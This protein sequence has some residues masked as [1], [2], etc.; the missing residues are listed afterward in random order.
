M[1]KNLLNPLISILLRNPLGDPQNP[2]AMSFLQHPG[3]GFNPSQQ[4]LLC[5]YLTNKNNDD[6]DGGSKG[7]DLIRELELYK[8]DPFD[9]P[10]AACFSYGFGAR[11]RH[12]YCYAARNVKESRGGRR[13]TKSGF[14]KRGMVRA[15]VGPGG[16]VVVGTRSSFV[17]YL[18]HLPKTA[19]RTDW[20]M[21]EYALI[22]HLKASFVLCRVFAQSR[23]G[24]SISENG[25]SSCA[26][27]SVSAVRHIGIQH[28]GYLTPDTL[29]PKMHD[30][31]HVNRNQEIPKYPM[32]SVSELDDLVMPGPVAV[33]RFPLP[34]GAQPREQMSS[35][36]PPGS[37]AECFEGLTDQQVRSIL[38]EDFIELADLVP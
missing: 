10:D 36:V 26:E 24:N 11:K 33:D 30:D 22:D 20:V 7:Y 31:N 25:L 14:W 6:D 38:E 21:H 3:S 2:G 16:E 12:W 5:Y 23:A 1:Y 8:Y 18:G 27:E 32:R 37:S 28:D 13:K 29:E 4:Q 15:V 9:L 19:T 34:S 35:S 17:F